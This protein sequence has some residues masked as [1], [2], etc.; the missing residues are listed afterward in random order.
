MINF[1]KETRKEL[2]TFDYTINDISVIVSHDFKITDIDKFFRIADKINYDCGYGAEEIDPSLKIYLKD[3]N[4]FER[5]EYDG[6]E[7]WEFVN[8][9]FPNLPTNNNFNILSLITANWGRI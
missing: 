1:G 2:A 9:G 3:G 6:A 5:R 7:W 4:Y 8:C